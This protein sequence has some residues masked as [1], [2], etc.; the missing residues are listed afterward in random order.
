M[1]E[2]QHDDGQQQQHEHHDDLITQ[3]V[4]SLRALSEKLSDLAGHHPGVAGLKKLLDSGLRF[5]SH[6]P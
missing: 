4:H 3:V 1:A 5:F 2:Q 6:I